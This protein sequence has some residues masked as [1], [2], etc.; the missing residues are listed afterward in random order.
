MTNHPIH[1]FKETL[2]DLQVLK[3]LTEIC[4]ILHTKPLLA[5]TASRCLLYGKASRR[6]GSDV[7]L[8]HSFQSS[9]YVWIGWV[10]ANIWRDFMSVAPLF[11]LKTGDVFNTCFTPFI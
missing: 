1:T 5:M 11:T 2:C 4:L 10:V 9:L 6:H 3:P 7:I 8:A